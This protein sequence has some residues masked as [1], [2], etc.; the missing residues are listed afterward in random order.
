[1]YLVAVEEEVLFD[2]LA[3]DEA[4]ALVHQASDCSLLHVRET[5]SSNYQISTESYRIRP[6]SLSSDLICLS[7]SV[8]ARKS[9]ACAGCFFTMQK[10]NGIVF[11][12]CQ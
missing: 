5:E 8:F 4:V 2:A 3:L 9:S 7:V 6:V 11:L 1:L 12:L 10:K